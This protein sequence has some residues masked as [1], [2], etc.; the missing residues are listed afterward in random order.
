[1]D[2][3]ILTLKSSI[4]ITEELVTSENSMCKESFAL[5]KSVLVG[6]ILKLEIIIVLLLSKFINN[7]KRQMFDMFLPEI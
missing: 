7:T 3:K 4:F 5:L 1:M 2:G 6:L